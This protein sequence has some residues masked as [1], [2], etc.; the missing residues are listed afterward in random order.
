MTNS[1]KRYLV[2]KAELYWCEKIQEDDGWYKCSCGMWSTKGNFHLHI[3]KQLD[4][5]DPADMYGKI[6]PA[7]KDLTDHTWEGFVVFLNHRITGWSIEDILT[8]SSKLTQVMLE[9][10]KE[11]ENEKISK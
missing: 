9:Y 4:P 5:L 6:I 3:A 1:D 11:K 7:I 2:E 8:S 10:F